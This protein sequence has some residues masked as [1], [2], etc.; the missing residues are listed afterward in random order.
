MAAREAATAQGEAATQVP[1]VRAALAREVDYARRSD[2]RKAYV[3]SH[4]SP[5]VSLQ[6]FGSG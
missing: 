1:A 2:L 5:L 4:D 6:K 3:A